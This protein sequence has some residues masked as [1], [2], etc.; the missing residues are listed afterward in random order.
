MHSALVSIRSTNAKD[1]TSVE[2]KKFCQL[3]FIELTK[4][5]PNPTRCLAWKE[6]SYAVPVPARWQEAHENTGRRSTIQLPT[7]TW[8]KL[9]I[10]SMT[11]HARIIIRGNM[12]NT[13]SSSLQEVCKEV[14]E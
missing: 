8:I 5:K 4:A 3:E 13:G 12:Y 10:G 2:T 1:S 6:G 7:H 11:N 9:S 14:E